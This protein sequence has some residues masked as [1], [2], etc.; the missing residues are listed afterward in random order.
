MDGLKSDDVTIFS[1]HFFEGFDIVSWC[2][3]QEP[4]SIV[5]A[6]RSDGKLLAFTWEQAQQVWGWTICETE[7]FVTSCCS[8]SE[9]GEDRVYITVRRPINGEA[10]TLIECMASHRGEDGTAR[11]EGWRV[12]NENGR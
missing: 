2:Y 5:W 12:G 9:D 10:R 1:P 11:R 6:V 8:I 3:S 7:G 4:R